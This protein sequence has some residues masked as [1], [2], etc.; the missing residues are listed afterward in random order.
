MIMR[1]EKCVLWVEADEMGLVNRA[2]NGL[3]DACDAGESIG[4]NIGEALLGKTGGKLGEFLGRSIGFYAGTA[5]GAIEAIAGNKYKFKCQNCG[6]EW[7]TDDDNDDQTEIYEEEQRLIGQVEEIVDTTSTLTAAT[8]EEEKKVH[9]KKIQSILEQFFGIDGYNDLKSYL[10]D[11]LAY[12]QFV[13][14]NNPYEALASIEKSLSLFPDDS[15][16]L[17]IKGMISDVS[18]KP[19]DN[20]VARK[21]LVSYKN[22][23]TD[24]PRT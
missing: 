12:S 11:A 22:L 8:S 14:H 10:Y 24:N 4:K 18:E 15:I 19:M 7:E 21:S 16:S 9:I 13:L 20:Y 5:N 2:A 23:D 1:C 6:H 3:V 17:S